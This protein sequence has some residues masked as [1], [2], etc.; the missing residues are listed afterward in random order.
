MQNY[1]QKTGDGMLRT[2]SMDWTLLL[3]SSKGNANRT[4]E[5]HAYINRLHTTDHRQICVE[6]LVSGGSVAAKALQVGPQR[7]M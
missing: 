1:V 6:G 4:L 3:H 7:Q 2:L 5:P